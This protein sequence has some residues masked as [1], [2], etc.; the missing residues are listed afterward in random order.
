MTFT[1]PLSGYVDAN[2]PDLQQM[3]LAYSV[4]IHIKPVSSFRLCLYQYIS[5][6]VA[7]GNHII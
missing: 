2:S 1:L 4:N 7:S 3:M 6:F 5:H